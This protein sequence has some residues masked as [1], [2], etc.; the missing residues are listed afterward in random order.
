MRHCKIL[1]LMP[2][3]HERRATIR[4]LFD[5]RCIPGRNVNVNNILNFFRCERETERGYNAFTFV[6]N[7]GMQIS[8]AGQCPGLCPASGD[9][10]ENTEQRCILLC[11]LVVPC[12]WEPKWWATMLSSLSRNKFLTYQSSHTRVPI[13]QNL[14]WQVRIGKICS[15]A[16]QQTGYCVCCCGE[17]LIVGNCFRADVPSEP[18]IT[19]S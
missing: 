7:V 6:H 2:C 4:C 15:E 3:I 14:H 16:F 13:L 18:F 11:E 1:L 19:F 9:G 5:L 10:S 12:C 8:A 17:K